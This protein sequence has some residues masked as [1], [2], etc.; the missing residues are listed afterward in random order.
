MRRHLFVAAAAAVA[1]L[2]G[3][4]V[5]RALGGNTADCASAQQQLNDAQTAL[6]VAQIALASAQAM[7]VG[8]SLAQTAVTTID[9]DITQIAGLVNEACAAPAAVP[10]FTA[11]AEA[12]VITL[13]Q[14]KKLAAA[15]KALAAA[16][17]SRA[18]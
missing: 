4:S 5:T 16:L 13:A 7:G 6:S 2:S 10:A 8:V 11:H 3:C 14:A 18:P 15:D 17:R 1:G 12:P 9:G